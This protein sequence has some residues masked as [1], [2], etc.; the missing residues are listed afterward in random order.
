MEL[1]CKR[2]NMPINMIASQRTIPVRNT[3]LLLGFLDGQVA[4]TPTIA[5][6]AL[7]YHPGHD[8]KSLLLKIPHV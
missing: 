6:S 1:P 3:L 7:G 2:G 8:D 4:E 5:V